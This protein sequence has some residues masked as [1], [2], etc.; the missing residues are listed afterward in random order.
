MSLSLLVLAVCLAAAYPLYQ[1]ATRRRLPPHPPG[2]RGW[3]IVGHLA[4]PADP[5]YKTY[6]RWGEA[7]GSDIVRINMFGHNIVA[8]NSLEA[9]TDLLDKR[10]Q[11]YSNRPKH[12]MTMVRDLCGF[13]Y[14]IAF[15][16]P[17]QF[18][19][20]QRRVFQRQYSQ[21]A[22]KR[23]RHAE[24]QATLSFLRNLLESP[25]DLFRHIRYVFG[26]QL[27]YSAYGIVTE[28]HDD[29]IIATVEHGLEAAVAAI[30]PGKFLVDVLPVLKYV[31]E[32]FPGAGFKRQA[33]IWRESVLKMLHVPFDQAKDLLDTR[34]LPDDCAIKTYL[35]DII[36]TSRDPEYAEKVIR[37]AL[38]A[39]YGAGSDTTVSFMQSFFL[40]MTLNPYVQKEAQREIDSVCRG[41]LP[42][43]SDYERLPYVHAIVKELLRWN[44]A[45]PLNFAH[46]S[47]QDDVYKG[48][49][50]PKDTIV[51]SNI[52]AI[53]H[54]PSIYADPDAFRP[55]RFLRRVG[56]EPERDP[57]VAYGFGRRICAGRYL[58]H[59][60]LWI[61]VASVLAAFDVGRV[62]DEKGEEVIPTGEY[63]CGFLQFPKPFPCTVRPR[64]AAYEKLVLDA[65]EA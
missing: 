49:Y 48:Y 45:V 36:P 42:D 2:P 51:I 7:Y 9:S 55:A 37:A 47:A 56:Y 38:T 60:V 33:K 34:G 27:V 32:W 57:D 54:D 20:D 44:P 16:Q 41:R 11:T 43:F 13:D 28:D 46:A 3:P 40:A 6:Q 17:G 63:E 50:I 35:T 8:T 53:L 14:A 61:T 10:S 18:W 12:G 24:T 4:A 22:I 58:A 30:N 21:Q 15:A 19:L 65:A 29:P 25:Q 1:Y 26:R 62:E 64:S 59:E 52:W 31:P 5:I 23:Y 39:A